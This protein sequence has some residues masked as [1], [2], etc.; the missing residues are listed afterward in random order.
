MEIT[1]EQI[2]ELLPKTTSLY[3]VAYNDSLSESPELLQ[4]CIKA[5]NYDAINDKIW[6]WFGEQCNSN[7]TEYIEELR[8]D[9]VKKYNITQSEAEALTEMYENELRDSITD[10]DDSTLIEDLLHN[11]GKQAMF[12]DTGIYIPEMYDEAEVNKALNTIKEFFAIKDEAHDEHLKEM[13]YSASYGG[14]LVIHFYED[15]ETFIDAKGSIKFKDFFLTVANI[16]NGSG[17]YTRLKDIEC[18]FELKRENIFIEK[19]IK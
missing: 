17:W 8:K 6:D 11:T 7:K 12:F 9:L 5:N 15:V 16:D 14:N 4:Q 13:L 1:L 2:K 10:R 3:Y 18:I 19:T